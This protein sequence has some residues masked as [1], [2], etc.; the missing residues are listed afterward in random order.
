MSLRRERAGQ[1]VVHRDFNNIRE[2]LELLMSENAPLKHRMKTKT[3]F[4]WSPATDVFE[5]ETEFVVVMDIAGMERGDISI[6]TDGKVLTIQGVRNE[7]SSPGKK[8]FYKME[9]QVGPFRRMIKIPMPIDNRSI[10]TSYS[11]GL[12]EVR[13]RKKF[14][15]EKPRVKRKINVE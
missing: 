12:L 7:V 14:E 4:E 2:L 3:G 10:S 11:K 6:F 5:T 9:I 15:G 8:Q 13:F 1:A